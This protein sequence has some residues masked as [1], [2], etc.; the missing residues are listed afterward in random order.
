MRSLL[1]IFLERTLCQRGLWVSMTLFPLFSG[2][3][4]EVDSRLTPKGND[5]NSVA[6]KGN[7]QDLFV[8]S[9]SESPSEVPSP[10][11]IPRTTVDSPRFDDVALNSGIEF[12]YDNGASPRRLMV[13]ATG[14]GAGWLD[15]DRDSYWDLYLVQGG[16]PLLNEE[17]QNPNDELFRNRAGVSFARVTTTAGI[18]EK[19]FGQGIAV[20]DF[21]GDGFDDI[22]ITNVGRD[23]LLKNQGDG[24]FLD[25][26]T[27]TL[28]PNLRWASS[29]AWADLDHDDDLDLFVCNYVKYDPNSPIPCF[30]ADG[31]PGICHPRDVDPETNR[32]YLNNADGTFTECLKEKGLDAAGSKSLGLVVADFNGDHLNDVYVANDTTA[33]HLFIARGDGT[34]IEDAVPA[35]CAANGLGQFQ[36]SM[37]VA[38]GDYD[39]D[40]LFDLY[41]THFTSDSNTLYKGLPGG[42]FDDTTRLTGIHKPTLNSLGFGTVMCDFNADGAMDLMVA[43]GH[44]DRSFASQGDNFEMLAQ[45]FSFN[46]KTWEEGTSAAG[47]Y[48]QEPRVGRAIAM[49]DYDNDGD[50]DVAIVNQRS[51]VA[52][53]QNLRSSRHWLK[54]T[55]VGLFGNRRGIG[56]E[57]LIKQ[58]ESK[59][60]QMLAGGTSYAAT[61]Q[62][63]IFTGFGSGDQPCDI[64]VRWNNGKVQILEG[65]KPD[66]E[67]L[68]LERDAK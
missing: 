21:D 2:C 40:G 28:E 49:A 24:T 42:S 60:R 45:L 19:R 62:P 18:V 23:T 29:A 48:F 25:V 51:Q 57:V 10:R 9:S 27:I 16:S 36:A 5:S 17:H 65:M 59:W 47:A 15:V 43:N 31:K 32:F 12:S 39:Q 64:S 56:M 58:G 20:G 8:V 44:I 67:I 33:N 50:P 26:T 14:G 34:F 1:R 22:Y 54:I 30:G 38:F 7:E 35:G 53:L 46:G 52:L 66:Q 37:G 11:E 61:H 55:P 3:S 41:C 4:G 13:E 6:G 63:M 68:V